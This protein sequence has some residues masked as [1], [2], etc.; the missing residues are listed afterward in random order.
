MSS[1]P[2]KTLEETFANA[3]DVPAAESAAVLQQIRHASPDR[4]T[5]MAAVKT[6]IAEAIYQLDPAPDPHGDASLT[7]LQALRYSAEPAGGILATVTVEKAA[8]Q[9]IKVLDLDTDI[10]EPTCDS[11]GVSG[12]TVQGLVTLPFLCEDCAE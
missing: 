5:A 3:E 1:S 2:P 8:E 12:V 7:Y 4:S 10:Q 9:I 11:D 6:L